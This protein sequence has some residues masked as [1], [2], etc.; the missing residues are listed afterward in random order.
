[1]AACMEAL[2]YR[3]FPIWSLLRFFWHYS[4]G[5]MWVSQLRSSPNWVFDLYRDP[6]W[7]ELDFLPPKSI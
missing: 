1:M 6:T 2:V 7:Q 5:D 3:R 4:S